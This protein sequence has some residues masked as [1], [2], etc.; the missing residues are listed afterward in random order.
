MS[1]GADAAGGAAAWGPGS[2]VTAVTRRRVLVV[3]DHDDARRGLRILLELVGHSVGEAAD[4]PGGLEQLLTREWEIALI[5]LGLPGLDGC[6]L[7]R[8]V[9]AAPGGEAICL[10]ALTGHGQPRVR[11]EVLDAGFDAH[12]VKPVD[13]AALQAVLRAGRGGRE[14]R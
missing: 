12:L 4:G 10:V 9:R 3:E 14:S 5:D 7:A 6:A 13:L 2:A 11:Q 1:L 8:A